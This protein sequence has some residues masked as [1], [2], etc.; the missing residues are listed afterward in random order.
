M[1]VK[2]G[3]YGTNFWPR[4][5]LKWDT[6]HLGQHATLLQQAKIKEQAAVL[7]RRI[8]TWAQ[9]QHLHLPVAAVLRDRQVSTNVMA[10]DVPIYLP[11][12]V[13]LEG[14]ECPWHL[15]EIE[16]ELRQGQALDALE[17]LQKFLLSHTAILQYKRD[18][19][20]GQYQGSRSSKAIESVGEKIG[21]CAA[22]YQIH[23]A[24]LVKTLTGLNLTGV[25]QVFKPLQDQDIC[26]INREAMDIDTKGN[27]SWSWIWMN[28]ELK[29][30]DK[31]SVAECKFSCL[32]AYHILCLIICTD[33]RISWVKSCAKTH[34]WQEE[35]LL[36]Q[37]EM[38]RTIAF[39]EFEAQEWECMGVLASEVQSP[40]GI[41]PGVPGYLEDSPAIAQDNVAY[42]ARQAVIHV[43]TASQ[44]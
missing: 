36:I 26:G 35:G 9:T 24:V 15:L 3:R 18:H 19:T 44:P 37:E 33:L 40:N 11:S 32:S 29:P 27:A 14:A 16:W 39:L 28:V 43:E 41:A 21:A 2:L 8:N 4:R 25:D 12:A 7:R 34:C 30:D 10:Y 1:F 5:Q 6:E 13:Y 42:A 38:R 20:H 17:L 31:K 22:C 23:Q